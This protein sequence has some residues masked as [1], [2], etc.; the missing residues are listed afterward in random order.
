MAIFVV[1]RVQDPVRM[2]AAIVAVFPNDNF[3][4]GNNEWLISA[5]GTAKA[6]SD[7]LGI[8]NEPPGS[9]TV[10][11][12]AIVFSMENYFGRAANDIWEW[13]KTKAE[14]TDG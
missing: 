6:L 14:A 8:T 10:A 3:D 7:R 12:N 9:Q 1:F 11:G 5:Q 2:R 4:L 13:I